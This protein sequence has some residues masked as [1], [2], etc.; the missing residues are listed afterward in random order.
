[1]KR[2]VLISL[3]VIMI[4]GGLLTS[5]VKYLSYNY[6]YSGDLAK[7]ESIHGKSSLFASSGSEESYSNDGWY[8]RLSFADGSIRDYQ[9]LPNDTTGKFNRSTL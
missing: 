8:Q 4:V 5:A 1:M 9:R 3:A 6:G 2:K 7:L